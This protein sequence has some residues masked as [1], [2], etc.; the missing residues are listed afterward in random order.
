MAILDALIGAGSSLLGGILGGNRADQAAERQAQLQR[1][2]AQTGIQWRVED[3]KKAG[4]SPY[5]ALGAQTASY[6]PVSVGDGGIGKGLS[7]AS[8]DLSRAAAAGLPQGERDKINEAGA[9]LTL[10]NQ[11]LQN[12]L[13]RVQIAKQRAQ[14][15]PAVPTLKKN[16][17]LIDGQP[18]TALTTVGGAPVKA[19]DIKQQADTI[20]E[21]ARLRPFGIKLYTNPWLS[22]A[23]NLE[24]RYGDMAEEVGGLANLAGD[25]GYT[26][27]KYWWPSFYEAYK[28]YPVKRR[29]RRAFQQFERR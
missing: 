1:E 20:P 28:S 16:G 18:A 22:D 6:S 2:F 27:M 24:N 5:Y 4:I 10:E 8:Q 13:L 26:A 12:D 15:A 14:L 3:A 7:D 25:V 23:Q 29:V 19:D 11:Q 17:T 21:T 9:K